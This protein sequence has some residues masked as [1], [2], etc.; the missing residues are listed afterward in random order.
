MGCGWTNDAKRAATKVQPKLEPGVHP[1]SGRSESYLP[2]TQQHEPSRRDV[3]TTHNRDVHGPSAPLGYAEPSKPTTIAPSNVE[4]SSVVHSISGAPRTQPQ[5]VLELRQNSE[6]VVKRRRGRPRKYPPKP[7]ASKQ[8]SKSTLPTNADPALH[9]LQDLPNDAVQD[10]LICDKENISP[11]SSVVVAAKR[12]ADELDRN[13]WTSNALRDAACKLKSF[14]TSGVMTKKAV[15]LHE[16]QKLAELPVNVILSD[17]GNNFRKKPTEKM[18]PNFRLKDFDKD[19]LLSMWNALKGTRQMDDQETNSCK[20]RIGDSMK[21]QTTEQRGVTTECVDDRRRDKVESCTTEHQKRPD[22]VLQTP[23]LEAGQPSDTKVSSQQAAVKTVHWKYPETDDVTRSDSKVPNAKFFDE[24]CAADLPKTSSPFVD[25]FDD[26]LPLLE[27]LGKPLF[28]STPVKLADVASSARSAPV[29]CKRARVRFRPVTQ[30]IDN[31]EEDASDRVEL[32]KLAALPS[33]QLGAVPSAT[34][35]SGVRPADIVRA[36][37]TIDNVA[38][39]TSTLAL[40]SRGTS[41]A[42]PFAVPPQQTNVQTSADVYQP[43]LAEKQIAAGQP[44]HPVVNEASSPATMTTTCSSNDASPPPSEIVPGQL[45]HFYGARYDGQPYNLSPST[46]G[47]VTKAARKRPIIDD[48]DAPD[49]KR[50]QPEVPV[51]SAVAVNTGHVTGDVA[52]PTSVRQP[53]TAGE[54]AQ[55][56]MS[57]PAAGSRSHPAAEMTSRDAVRRAPNG[58]PVD[59]LMRLQRK[60]STLSSAATLRRVVQIIGETGR[61]CV[62]DV[63]FDFDLCNLDSTT[64][65]RLIQC[66]DTAALL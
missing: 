31:D 52:A 9:R 14:Q 10:R 44:E 32:S 61:Y 24:P 47:F 27:S 41:L 19:T 49:R 65:T 25:D 23:V 18:T 15:G 58:V 48:F 45:L 6:S 43:P 17:D 56:E 55:P 12:N 13:I 20:D 38:A 54:L 26:K 34:Q 39:A 5:T 3:P 57:R 60:L 63:T 42:V 66:L 64:V 40:Q 46:G 22:Q 11:R 8:H 62:N 29:P 2:I 50:F 16:R 53:V 1:F 33:M 59:E 36:F 7:T 51:T 28:T 35:I 4:Q 37:R 21:H 30:A